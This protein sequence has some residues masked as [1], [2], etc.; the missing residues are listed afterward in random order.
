M[1]RKKIQPAIQITTANHVTDK[2]SN[3]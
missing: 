2:C 3:I 1:T